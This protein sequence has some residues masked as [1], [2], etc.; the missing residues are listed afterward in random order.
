MTGSGTLQAPYTLAGQ[1]LAPRIRS[2]RR[3]TIVTPI[4]ISPDGLPVPVASL[5]IHSNPVYVGRFAHLGKRPFA[6]QAQPS[7]AFRT[8]ASHTAKRSPQEFAENFPRPRL[9]DLHP[10]LAGERWHIPRH[11]EWY[12][13][14]KSGA[15]SIPSST[16]V[17]INVEEKREHGTVSKAPIGKAYHVY[18]I[19]NHTYYCSWANNDQC[20]DR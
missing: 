9:T 6:T 14:G 13:P 16:I 18:T 1:S 4:D 5:V 11:I 7:P 19:K 17:R 10:P 15:A 2:L 3:Y 12:R 8:V 20:R